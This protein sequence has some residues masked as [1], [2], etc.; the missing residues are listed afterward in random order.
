MNRNV[1]ISYSHSGKSKASARKVARFLEQLGLKVWLDQ[2]QIK[3]G[4]KITDSVEKGLEES[5]CIVALIS[6]DAK[7]SHDYQEELAKALSKG[8][9]IYP[10][11]ID[12][13]SAD[14]VPE[15]IKD[16]VALDLSDNDFNE[17]TK[18]YDAIDE[19]RSTWSKVKEYIVN[20]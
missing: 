10:V 13:A 20:R 16:R 4:D 5:D 1:F 15:A 2:E 3:L 7:D 6:P 11:I 14:D 9:F 17:L 12:N 18:L 8:K 19:K